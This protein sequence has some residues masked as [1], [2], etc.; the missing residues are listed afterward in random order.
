M[1]NNLLDVLIPLN[2][3]LTVKSAAILK[4]VSKT[5]NDCI[6]VKN[7]NKIFYFFNLWKENV[8]KIKD[9]I[10]LIRDYDDWCELHQERLYEERLD[11]ERLDEELYYCWACKYSDCD[12]H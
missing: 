3:Y 7:Y 11:E 10:Q 4:S 2:G 5:C 12:R 8:N 1:E 9:E 6:E